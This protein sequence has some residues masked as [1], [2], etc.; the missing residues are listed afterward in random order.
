MS[1]IKS[2]LLLLSMTLQCVACKKENVQL[3]PTDSRPRGKQAEIEKNQLP[4]LENVT[5]SKNGTRLTITFDIQDDNDFVSIS[6]AGWNE[7]NDTWTDI[8]SS[9]NGDIGNQ[10]GVGKEKSI[11]I[12]DLK[13]YTKLELKA[14]DS[15]VIDK[16]EILKFISK[17]RIEEDVRKMSGVRSHQNPTLLNKTR[18]FIASE[19]NSY[20]LETSRH[21][22]KHGSSNVENVIGHLKGTKYPESRYLICAHFD[23]VNTTPGAD[24]N[25]SGTAGV[26][27]AMRVL[28]QFQFEYSIDFLAFDLEEFGLVGSRRYVK[29]IASGQDIKGVFNFEMIGYPCRSHEC[30]HL[31][32]ET[33]IYNIAVPESGELQA[34]FNFQGSEYVSD[35]EIHS[36]EADG[37]F[38]YRRSDHAPFWAAGF[39]ALFLTDGANFRNPHY[40]QGSDTPETLDYEFA[41]NIVRTTVLT[42]MELAREDRSTSI[43]I[44]L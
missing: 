2:I 38:N 44:K 15:H 10:V 8:S 5:A 11:D 35:L 43:E 41:A 12:N 13:N 18:E 33:S 42:I 17:D 21:S 20:E 37:D 3:P 6:I 16:R 22:F 27:E 29:D 1:G 32:G 4:I 23:T 14:T 24:D 39:Q 26:L 25:A 36:V 34:E 31:D 30:Q 9:S 28:S 7:A 19:F 40:H